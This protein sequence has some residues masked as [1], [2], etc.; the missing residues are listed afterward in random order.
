[1]PKPFTPLHLLALALVTA[2]G[3]SS[4][5]GFTFAE[6]RAVAERAPEPPPPEP[7]EPVYAG[8]ERLR[9]N[10]LAMRLGIPVFW[11][12]DAND[13]DAIDPDEVRG[14]LFHDTEGA[15]TEDG[16]FTPVF[17]TAWARIRAADAAPTPDDDRRALVRR[18]LDH[19]AP[20]LVHTDVASLPPEHQAFARHM[21]RVAALIDD[22][23]AKQ[24][25]MHALADQLGD[26]L[27]SRSLFRRNWGARCR[28]S[29][30]EREADCSSVEGAPAQPVDVYPQELQEQ[31]FCQELEQRRDSETLLSPFTVVREQEGEL[32]A[33]PYT[34][35]YANE[36][37]A[38][39]AELEAAAEAMT[40][41][42]EQPLV[43][44][45][46]AAATAFRTNDW[47]PA[48]EAW[49]R[50][51]ARN[52]TWYV[53]VGPDETYWD[54]CSHKAGF[55]LTLARINRDSLAWQDRLTPLQQQMEQSLASLAP[56]YRARNVAFHMPDFIDIVVNAGDD[57][58]PFGAT[59]GQSLP[60]WGTVAEEGRGRT[61]AMSNLYT[62]PDSQAMRRAQAAA[63]L[64]PETMETYTTSP[65]PGL[66]STILHEASH[67][68]GPTNEYR[69]RG[70]TA[71]QA[72]GGGLA[73]MLEELKSQT[74]ALYFIDL[75]KER[76]VIDEQAAR[77][78]Y[79]D[80]IVWAFGHISRGMYTPAGGRK[81]Y[82]QLAAIQ[83]GFLMENG[84]IR[85]DADAPTAD[86][87]HRGA[88]TVDFEKMPEASRELMQLVMRIKSTNDRR[89]AEELATR[90]VDGEV[91]PQQV[92][93]ERY[94]AFPQAA[95]VYSVDL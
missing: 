84:A 53:R 62:D 13:N 63:L 72:F 22:L 51:N 43:T 30:T 4:A 55:H 15:W 95:F 42:A 23:Y 16:R 38:I 1:M 69:Y 18:E 27:E 49:S 47:E 31:G 73:S 2:C 3:G 67:N 77:E 74:G 79:L 86:G 46:R 66:L 7:E 61:V 88:F 37:Q 8:L 35:H 48:D 17:A 71:D 39:A 59:I 54:P 60:N 11:V 82:S 80:S 33:V 85:F 90:F 68:L 50:M 58:D 10:Q 94:R 57:R 29:T 25:G 34:E 28:G 64:S 91:V 65:Q 81:A 24:V 45:L 89:G 78:A 32:V 83:I 14:L 36:M 87:E 76:G 93:V 21:L 20:T 92:I 9:F 19:A 26:D 52:S 41:P 70:R 12:R 40:D 44:Y 75:L 5:D 56:R 6:P